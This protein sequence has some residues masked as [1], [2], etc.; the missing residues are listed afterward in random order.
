WATSWSRPVPQ[1]LLRATSECCATSWPH[2]WRPSATFLPV[3]GTSGPLRPNASGTDTAGRPLFVVAPSVSERA[4]IPPYRVILGD[5]HEYDP[6]PVGVTDPRLHQ[7][8]ELLL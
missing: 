8:P 3:T 4:L 7:A 2:P 6:H 5:L 1:G